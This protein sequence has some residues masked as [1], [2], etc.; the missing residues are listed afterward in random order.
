MS[1]IFPTLEAN[2]AEEV[3]GRKA[4]LAWAKTPRI[5]KIVDSL[6]YLVEKYNAYHY[7]SVYP[8]SVSIIIELKNLEGLKD[9]SLAD[10]LYSV[11][12]LSPDETET[13]DYPGNLERDYIFFWYNTGSDPKWHQLSVRIEAKFKSDSETCKKVL[14]GY[15]EARE[16]EPIYELRC[17]DDTPAPA[18]EEA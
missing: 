9:Q 8:G 1:H 10:M 4:T 15:R 2:V 18:P 5:A 11:V 14:V 17:S 12:C 7:S 13:S 16:P 6:D 3:A